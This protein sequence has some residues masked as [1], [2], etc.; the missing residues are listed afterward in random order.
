[1]LSNHSFNALLKTLE[2]PPEHVKFLLATTEPEKLPITVI[3]RCLH[4]QLLPLPATLITSHISHILQQ[5]EIEFDA[6][7]ISQIAENSGGSVR[8]ALS[9][10]D[11]LIALG[12]GQISSESVSTLLGL[13]KP[14]L[15]SEL[16]QH[17]LNSERE[18]ALE[19][20][21]EMHS[22]GIA[23]KKVLSQ[24][25]AS[26]HNHLKEI[27]QGESQHPNPKDQKELLHYF[28]QIAVVGMRDFDFNP[29]DLIAMNMTIMRMLDF[30]KSPTAIK[31][32]L[33]IKSSNILE[34]LEVSGMTKAIVKSL[35]TVQHDAQILHL[36]LSEDK[37]ALLTPI[38]IQKIKDAVKK[39]GFTGTI[40]IECG[41]PSIKSNK[42][43]AAFNGE[44]LSSSKRD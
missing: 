5:E 35:E 28:Y 31:T 19:L 36:R 12:A 41:S 8:D 18:S 27:L 30:N 17:I 7:A 21:S 43:S 37:R 39:T 14:K 13:S 33:N 24:I 9:S 4:F 38:H 22:K 1:M 3:S 23:L 34:A 29:S 40:K 15:I 6:T 16:M 10:T 11:Q 26:I 2:E 44:V 20:I 42:I 25:M 32:N